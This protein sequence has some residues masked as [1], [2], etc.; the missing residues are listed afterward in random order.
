VRRPGGTQAIPRPPVWRPGRP[1]P[2]A[3]TG[4]PPL[5]TADLASLVAARGPG[6]DPPVAMEDARKSAVLVA[7]FDGETGPEVI[8]TRRAWHLSSH[9][10]EVSFPGGRLD[11]GETPVD[12]ARREAYEEVLLDPSIIEVVGEL[13]HLATVV[14]RSL[15]VPVVAVLPHRPRLEPGTDE[16][17][18]ILTVPLADL[19]RPDT[20]REERWGSPPLDRGVFF[21]ELDDETVW[22][23]TARI[24]VQLLA[25]A[26]GTE[27]HEGDRW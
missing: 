21:F 6:H 24:L 10:G 12:A 13:D 11:P 22:G 17:D 26:S 20:Y 9:K 27:D 15:I 23:A 25:V 19:A 5:A 7:L 18:R 1:A 16:V 4:F 8:L 3:A 14:S 2:W